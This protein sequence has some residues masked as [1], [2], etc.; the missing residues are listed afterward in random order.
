MRLRIHFA[1]KIAVGILAAV[2]AL[3][4]V[5]CGDKEHSVPTSAE[6]DARTVDNIRV[7]NYF[8][9]GTNREYFHDVPHRVLSVGANETE[10]L[11]DLGVADSIL[12]ATDG[13]NNLAFDIKV[14]NRR[15]FDAVPKMPRTGVVT[16]TVLAMQPDLIL[17][18][19]QFFSKKYL[20][21]TDY[22]NA[23]GIYTM[24]PFNTTAPSKSNQRE[25]LERE[26]QFIRD[27]GIIFHKEERAERIV[28]DTYDRIALVKEAVK[29][30]S[31]PRV[32]I[33]DR[34]SVLA[35]YGR[36]KIA[37]DMVTAL[38]AEVP[39]T[40]AAIAEEYLMELDPDVVFLVVYRNEEEELAF[41]RD[42]PALQSL[43]FIRE[44]RLYGIPLK[45]VYGPQ[46]RTID[47]VGYMAECIWPGKFHFPKEYV[48]LD[49]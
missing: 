20:G 1:R 33:L 10:L 40:P 42:N 46:T 19:Q 36:E 16:E 32:M 43:K 39:N 21:S 34:M 37:G 23:R 35:S 29:E 9:M 30:E 5:G 38:G 31:V 27:M 2:F 6:S 15:V 25:T 26:M 3:S 48:V 45:Y 4:L 41:L 8:E 7:E 44:K 17:A 14:A 24:V 28:R 13:Q 18:Q 12:S 49:V 22:W 47:A 11:L